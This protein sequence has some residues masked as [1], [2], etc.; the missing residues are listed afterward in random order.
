MG[1]VSSYPNGTF[2]WIDLG[3]D[4]VA[5]AK[6]FYGELFG[7]DMEDLRAGEATYVMC[8]L[9]GRDV[10]AIYEHPP[11]DRHEWNSFIS[12]DDVEQTTSKAG[13][14]G[15]T[16]LRE[17]YD[18]VDSSRRSLI[19][20]R[21]G[22]TVSLWQPKG[23]VGAGL[24]NEVG[25]WSWNELV[26]TEMDAAR[27]FYGEFLGWNSEDAPGPIPRATFT[28]G[29]L[30]VGGVHVPAPQEG[31]ASRWTVS[32]RVAGAD[33]AVA[34]AQELGGAVLLPPMDIPIGRFAIVSDP[35]GAAFTVAEFPGGPFRGVDGS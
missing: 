20:D 19:G 16:V 8:R 10:A 33:E 15:A 31:D 7:W 35:A 1:Q 9:Q 28:L 29:R 18:G 30:L 2:N 27:R 11:E 22:A 23:H 24:V 26:T 13:G 6:T 5:G 3:T 25:S 4:D 17:P 21:T 32:F 34:R 14:L 12:V